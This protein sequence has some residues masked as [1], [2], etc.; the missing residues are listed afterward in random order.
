[1]NP[2]RL[3]FILL[4]FQ[5]FIFCTYAGEQKIVVMRHGEAEHNI[6]RYYNSNP[7]HPDYQEANL[8]ENGRKSVAET[9]KELLSQCLNDSNIVVVFV[10][11]LPRT[12]QTAEIL[13]KE[14]VVSR[15]KIVI[16]QRLT[17][18]GAGDLEG[19]PYLPDWNSCDTQGNHSETL[20]EIEERINS[21]YGDMI[22]HYPQGNILVITHCCPA[23]SLIKLMTHENIKLKT[24]EAKVIVQHAAASALQP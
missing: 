2:T 8:T 23:N 9:A 6:G 10:S 7:S 12:R 14:G 4:L 24:A 17:E 19:K 3:L 22:K 21:F 16:D 18:K 13:V 1:M 5:S 15:D 11:P 20:Q